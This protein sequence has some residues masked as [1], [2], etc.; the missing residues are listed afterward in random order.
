M[1]LDAQNKFADAQTVTTNS[2]SGVGVVSEHT[3]DLSAAGRDI[4]NGQ[5]L[6]VVVEVTTAV[7]S[8]GDNE[9]MDIYLITDDDAALGSPTVLQKLCTVPRSSAAGVKVFGIIAPGHTYLRYIGLKFM[10][11]DGAFTAGAYDAYLT[12]NPDIATSYADNV[13]ISG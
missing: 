2:E 4:G 1:I 3:I 5:P 13:T 7:A 6:F 10:S 9:D 12:L 8:S 11:T